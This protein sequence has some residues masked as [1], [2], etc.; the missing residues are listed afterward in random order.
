MR[1]LS[2]LLI[3]SA[4]WAASFDPKLFSD[5]RW[6]PIGPLRGGRT[7][8]AAGVPEPAERLLHR[9]LQRRR[10]EDHRLRPH[11]ES[12]L[13]RPA[14]RIDRRARG[15]AVRPERHLRRQR[16]RTAAARPLRS[17]TASTNRPTPA[18]PGPISDCATDSRFRRSRSTRAIPNRLFVAVLGHPYGPNAERGLYRST[19]GGRTFEKVLGKDENTGASDVQI[20]PSNPDVVYAALWEARQGPWENSAW[21]GPGGGIFKSTDGGT[22]WKP[23]TQGIPARASSRRTSRSRRAIR[24]RLYASIATAS[25]VGD[26]PLGRCRRKLD[27]RHRRSASRR[28]HRRRRSFGAGGRS[29]ESRHRVRRQHGGLEIDG[30]RQD[31]DR[32]SAARPAATIISDS[33]SIRITPKSSCWSATRA[34]SSRS[35]AARPGVP[36]TT[37]RPRRCTTSTPTT[38]SRTAFAAGSRRAARPA[39]RAAATTARSRSASG[40]RSASRS[41]A[42]RCPIRSIRISSTAA[43][44]RASTAAPGRSR[45]SRRRRSARPT[46]ATLRTAPV[47]FSQADPHV[48]FFA[49]NTLWKT[50]DGGNSWQQIS[51]DLTRKTWEIPASVGKYQ[52]T[53]AA[54]P[55][56]RGVIYTIAPSP[57]DINRIWAGTDDGL[58]HTTADGGAHWKDVTPPQL[59]PWMKVSILDAGHFDA[60]TAYAAINT[61]RLDDL[62]PHIFR[63]HDG[64]KTWTEIVNGI[65]DGAPV[66]AVR[67]DPKRKGLLFAGTEREVYVSFDDGDNWQSLRLNMP[68]SSVRDIIVHDDDLIAATHGRGFWILDDITPL[69][70]LERSVATPAHL[71]KPQ[72]ADARALEHE[73]RHAAAA[74]R[75]GVEESA[76]R[77]D[78]SIT[79]SARGR[80]RSGDAGDS[81]CRRAP[82]CADIRAPIPSAPIDPMFPVPDVLGAAAAQPAGDGRECTASCGTC[83]TRRCRAA[84]G[85]GRPADRGDRARHRCRRQLDL[86][87]CRAATRSS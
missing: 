32:R 35:T 52:A 87:R 51:P 79:T 9:R 2:L 31:V 18:R 11:L 82:S 30:R 16:R 73:H 22:T 25:G 72:T 83:T 63:T 41:T 24:K 34:R 33:G 43:R 74:R 56:Q 20:D 37:S 64:G 84:D 76:R 55:T 85:R 65:P 10:L 47:V 59:G 5:L 36:G 27:A 50:A 75:A 19:D 66:D 70:Q 78:R 1:I 71:F 28:T 61:L 53:S 86:G 7:K 62:R 54:A 69:R 3:A 6:R 81:G 8:S 17:A 15:R 46:C 39:S 13:R 38:P 67:E 29:E 23:L 21:T 45:T 14:D 4:G 26:L 77:R 48:L 42:T 80:Y 40:I 49:A 60:L 44:S 58:I 57:L 12:D 68:A